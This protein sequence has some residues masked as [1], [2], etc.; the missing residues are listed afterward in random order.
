MDIQMN[1]RA[2]RAKIRFE[3]TK[4]MLS[5]EQ[6]WDVPLRSTRGDFNLDNIARAAHQANKDLGEASFVA[7]RRRTTEQV[8]AELRLEVV[9]HVIAVKLKEEEDVTPPEDKKGK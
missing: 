5:L 1:E 6:L 9:K 3:S 8:L 7:T 4:G 2:L